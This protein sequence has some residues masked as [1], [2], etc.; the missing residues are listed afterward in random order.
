MYMYI[1]IYIWVHL[2]SVNVASIHA[3][4]ASMILMAYDLKN[5]HLES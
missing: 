2:L 1:Y 4:G 3:I 5:P